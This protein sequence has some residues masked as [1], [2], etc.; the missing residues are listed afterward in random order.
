M[1]AAVWHRNNPG[2]GVWL[3][4]L[5]GLIRSQKWMCLPRTTICWRAGGS[6][7]PDA[8]VGSGLIWSVQSRHAHAGR[9]DFCMATHEGGK[10]V[11]QICSFSSNACSLT[12]SVFFFVTPVRLPDTPTASGQPSPRGGTSQQHPHASVTA[13]QVQNLP[14]RGQSTR[15]QHLRR[16]DEGETWMSPFRAVMGPVL[17]GLNESPAVSGAFRRLRKTL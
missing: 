12:R 6:N 4:H 16:D 14:E 10:D 13:E 7:W 15:L 9:A 2:R 1:A 17:G 11:Q 8:S 3:G 5:L